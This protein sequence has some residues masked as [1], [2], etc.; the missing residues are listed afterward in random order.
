[1]QYPLIQIE[2]LEGMR[3]YIPDPIQL[4]STYEELL[5]Q[6]NWHPFP[7]WAKI[8]PAAIALG[9]FLI[10]NPSWIQNKQ[11]LEMGAG[12]GLPSFTIAC[13]A[14]TVLVSDHSTEAVALLQ[15][16]I[17]FID[18]TNVTAA[19]IDWNA[20]PNNINA[21]VILLS[22][23]NYAPDQ[24]DSLLQLINQFL[25]NG[26]TIII[27][28]PQRIMGNPFI[29]AL[30]PYIKESRVDTITSEQEITDISILVLYK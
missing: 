16:N 11:V 14:K 3:I 6:N 18:A 1:M 22:D 25:L 24:F 4:K 29:N 9:K 21:D 10:E 28:T 13:K 2:P 19:C 23:I 17:E 7:F 27:S 20:F 5:T 12:I 15:K 26:T 30:Q 8:W